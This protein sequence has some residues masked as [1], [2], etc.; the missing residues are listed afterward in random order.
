MVVGD[1]YRT[2]LYARSH[3]NP[4]RVSTLTTL[5]S[6]YCAGGFVARDQASRSAR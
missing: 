5:H 2:S 1:L 4:N 3:G 6:R